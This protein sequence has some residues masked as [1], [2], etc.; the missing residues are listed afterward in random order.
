MENYNKL[1]KKAK[2]AYSKCVTDAEKRRLEAIFPE[3]KEVSDEKI[4]K[5]ILDYFKDLDEHGYPTK[6]WI[7]WIE[8]QEEREN[9]FNKIQVSDKVTRNEDGVIVNLSQL[10]RVVNEDKEEEQSTNTLE[11]TKVDTDTLTWICRI[12]YRA[13][14]DKLITSGD[15]TFLAKWIDKWLNYNPE[16]KEQDIKMLESIIDCIDGTGLLDSDQIDWIKSLKPEYKNTVENDKALLEKQGE[17][18]PIWSEEDKGFLDLLLAIFTNEHPNGLFT[19]NGITVFNGDY[20]SSG[21]IVTWLQS[22]KT[23]CKDVIEC[24]KTLLGK[25]DEQKLAWSDEDEYQINTILHGLNLKKEIYKKR[26]NKVEEDRY[27]TQ[28]NWLKSFEARCKEGKLLEIKIK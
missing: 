22:F 2:E 26:R 5:E 23:K 20:V 18:K 25:Q 15:E 6:E 27:N 17:Q 14:Q 3:L 13:R 1:L 7:A 24:N 11:W 12:I 16:W 19:T 21:R 8:K 28:Y 4:R 10:E 9:F